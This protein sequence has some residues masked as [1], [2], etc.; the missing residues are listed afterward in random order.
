M[1]YIVKNKNVNSIL[2][3]HFIDVCKELDKETKIVNCSMET[4]KHDNKL[5]YLYILNKG[6]STVKGGINVLYEMD[7]PSE[8]IEN[9]IKYK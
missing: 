9:T 6:I 2:T 4:K 8:I 1:K 3:T 5:E 7:Y